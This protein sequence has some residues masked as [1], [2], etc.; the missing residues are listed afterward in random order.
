MAKLKSTYA[1]QQK[2]DEFDVYD[3]IDEIAEVLQRSHISQE[4]Y[5][6]LLNVNDKLGHILH[7]D[8]EGL[9]EFPELISLENPDNWV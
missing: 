3:L 5:N 6:F 8:G 4:T 9:D 1:L 2:A 7:N